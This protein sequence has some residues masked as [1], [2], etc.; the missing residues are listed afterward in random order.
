MRL[1]FLAIFINCFVSVK[2]ATY[3]FSSL[4]GDDSR[5]SSQAQNTATPWKTIAKLNAYFPNLQPGDAVLFK[6]GETFYGQIIIGKSGSPNLPI[7]LGDYGSGAKPVISG[8]INLSGWTS[9][10]SGIWETTNS[11]LT[12]SVNILTIDGKI[13][14][15]GRY[16]N[17]D[18]ANKGYL[19]YESH[20]G[21]T[22]ITDNQLASSPSWIG[23]EVVIRKNRW[24]LDKGTITQHSGT[25]LT[26][27][28][29][30]PY[31]AEDNF[32]YFIQNHRST[33]DKTG[34]WYLNKATKK[35][36]LLLN[37][38][39]N[40][41]NQKIK[42]SFIN[43]LIQIVGKNHIKFQNLQLE[44]ANTNGFELSG[45]STITVSNC[46]I[47]SGI[48]GI[49][50]QNNTS[51]LIENTEIL[52]SGNTG[53]YL[54][55]ATK[56]ILRN[57]TITNTGVISGMGSNGD[58]TYQAVI[59]RGSGNL[60]EKNTVTN[61]GYSALRFEG[62]Y[63]ILQN[64][65]VS[66]FNL[67]K[68]DGGG[69]YTWNGDA[70]YPE[71]GSK[72]L[73]NIVLNGIGASGGTSKPADLTSH[74]IY[75]D[76][77]T[78]SVEVKG[79]TVA[80]CNGSGIFLHNANHIDVSGNTLFSN[81]WQLFMQQNGVHQIRNN[82]INQNKFFA[83][84]SDQ[85]TSRIVTNLNDINQFGTFD[86]NFY[87]RPLDDGFVINASSNSGGSGIYT[88][89][90]WKTAF[91]LDA[92]SRK[93]PV[94]ISSYRL[95]T[96]TGNNKFPNGSFMSHINN[97]YSW[98]Q[99]GNIALGWSNAGGLDAG[100]MKATFNTTINPSVKDRSALITMEIGAVSAA[101]K[102]ILKFSL[103]GTRNQRNF[104]VYLRKRDSPYNDLTT[105]YH[106][107]LS[108]SRTENEFAFSVPVSENNA[109]LVFQVDQADGTFF[110]DNLQVVEADLSFTNPD[111]VIR[112]EYNASSV[113]K[114]F[115][116]P[117][118]TF[119][120]LENRTYQ[121][122]GT[123]A[124][125]SSVILLKKPDVAS[126]P[127]TACVPPNAPTI[128]AS[129]LAITAG[130]SVTLTAGNCA[131]TVIWST[132]QT[133][134]PV[135]VTPTATTSYTAICKQT[136]ACKSVPSSALTIQVNPV[137][138]P[139]VTVTGNFEGYLD[140]VE[141]G[142]IRGWVWDRNKPND[143][144]ML[145]FFANGTSIGTT[146]ADLYR[147]D[148]A[149]AGKGN[150]SHGYSFTTPASIKTG[151][152]YLISAKVQNST[153]TLSWSPKTLICAP[154]ARLIAS[155]AIELDDSD[156][157]VTPNPIDREFEV[158]FYTAQPMDS[159]VSVVD[160]LGRSWYKKIVEGAG[161]HRQKII[162]QGAS[163]SYVVLIRQGNQIRSKKILIHQ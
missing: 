53:I 15:M 161:Y 90:D 33:L 77:N 30:S 3:Y 39:I 45:T 35:V 9:V 72:V 101:K 41:N 132:N 80:F 146:R 133:G 160:Q 163:G 154:N 129:S 85:L 44:G 40:P 69:I 111:D 5:T 21:N 116:L 54:T 22:R 18:A 162:L 12:S 123:L 2:A 50:G 34:E 150:G 142:S 158:S 95:N 32:G 67:V 84:K 157:K 46:T 92:N 7:V 137:P 8:F 47:T 43:T 100:C 49:V 93:A 127:P 104:Q 147:A 94:P 65:F 59:I 61:T 114:G 140:K 25:S 13:E 56:A 105:R 42:A 16:P 91:N 97:A 11:S 126:P 139:P 26:Y 78:G 128:S 82:S 107:S 14:P 51:V 134:S 48:N 68:D 135:F 28:G 52:N 103:L 20:S 151:V 86:N 143:P 63:T 10:G 119:V 99:S 102:Y 138:S 110:V 152:S 156:F 38:G 83:K 76:D 79:N 117:S 121:G 24:I 74:G 155:E 6:R 141:C 31:Q 70:T 66:N 113:S 60:V 89:S 71:K 55:A 148:L 125:W 112:F 130:Q 29:S 57:N 149:A 153:F 23:A 36:S 159:E 115:N 109:F 58:D 1:F 17:A 118:G 62:D 122:N 131:H 108:T 64:N 145:E 88:L 4:T 124:P 106:C 75:M 37:S 27:T 87:S 136:D 144:L 73:N 98:S 96:L 120:D 19:T 81:G